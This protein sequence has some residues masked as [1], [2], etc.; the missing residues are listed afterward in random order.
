MNSTQKK[1][2][3]TMNLLQ[4]KTCQCYRLQVKSIFSTNVTLQWNKNSSA[5]G[6][7]IERYKGGKWTNVAR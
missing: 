1:M 7:E 5:S 4:L 6:Y 2:A 3:L